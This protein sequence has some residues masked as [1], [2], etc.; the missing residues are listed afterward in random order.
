M[1]EADPSGFFI[2][3]IQVKTQNSQQFRETFFL[4]R[5]C[6]EVFAEQSMK[7]HQMWVLNINTDFLN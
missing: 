2:S 4:L 7:R 3:Y 1:G 6:W 5:F